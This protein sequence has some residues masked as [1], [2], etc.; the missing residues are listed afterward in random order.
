VF[1]KRLEQWI[2]FLENVSTDLKKNNSQT[3]QLYVFYKAQHVPRKLTHLTVCVIQSHVIKKSMIYL[4]HNKRLHLFG[5][6]KLKGK[7]IPNI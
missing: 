4:E 3:R 5:C 7:K 1:R 6:Q 2:F